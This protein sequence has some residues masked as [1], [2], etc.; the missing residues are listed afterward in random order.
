MLRDRLAS[1]RSAL[2]AFGDRMTSFMT[3]TPQLE[4]TMDAI[5]SKLALV[6]EGTKKTTK[7][8]EVAAE[9]DAQLTRV[10][11]RVQFV[12]KL[13]G[14]V[15]TLHVLTAD[16]DRKLADQL[17]RRSELDTLKSQCD[18]VIAQMLDAQQKI[19]QVNALQ[20]KVLPISEKLTNLS[21]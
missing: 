3:R 20:T 6:D 5:N 10:S 21:D 18:G 14:R 11:A 9:L 13:E 4:A 2:E 15:N 12:E 1:D 16:V 17:S 8:A 7:L 19:E